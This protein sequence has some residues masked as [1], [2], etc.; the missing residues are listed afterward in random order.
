MH[1][2]PSM[3]ID[4]LL[5]AQ[6]TV[7][8]SNTV[9]LDFGRALFGPIGGGVFAAMVALSCFGALNGQFPAIFPIAMRHST[10]STQ[11]HHSRVRGSST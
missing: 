10:N 4:Q 3:M 11:G 1:R 8:M 6:A 5:Y 2:V 7:G 9:A